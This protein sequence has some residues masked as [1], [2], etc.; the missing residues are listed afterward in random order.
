MEQNS[1]VINRPGV[2]LFHAPTKIS[3]QINRELLTLFTVPDRGLV[4]ILL[5]EPTQHTSEIPKLME[6]L[7]AKLR[8]EL[9][10]GEH[11]IRVKHFGMS[12][13]NLALKAVVQ[14]WCESKGLEVVSED[15]GRGVARKI[16]VDSETGLAGVSYAEGFSGESWV[17]EGSA[18][19]R[20]T[21]SQSRHRVLCLSGNSVKRKLCRQAAEELA[22]WVSENPNDPWEAI[23][24]PTL[25]IKEFS[26]VVISDDLGS[27]P[28]AL[29]KFIETLF[30]K[31]PQVRAFWA[32]T[33]RPDYAKRFLT[34]PP[35]V[36]TKV[37]GFKKAL[38]S[39]LDSIS[40][41][42]PGT[43]IPF[44]KEN[45]PLKKRSAT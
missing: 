28:K 31:N 18:R 37:K 1:I 10:I 29:K 8:V 14:K 43:V 34:L 20:K 32:G 38:H 39:E 19:G 30:K 25:P 41:M 7:L 3:L 11:Q 27:N 33:K 45:S 17:D 21:T 4:G 9:L 12:H 42:Q 2:Y 22:H 24:S 13:P 26:A 5:L 40:G 15:V 23:K 6:I 35:L 44:P 16:F 36:P